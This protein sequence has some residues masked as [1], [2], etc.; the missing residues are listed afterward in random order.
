[1]ESQNAQRVFLVRLALGLG[2][3]LA[4]DLLYSAFDQKAWPATAPQLFAPLAVVAVFVPL[5]VSQGLGNI[6]ATTLL[7]WTAAATL[8]VAGL[9]WY[10]VWRAWPGETV[11]VELSARTIFICAVFLFVAHA[12]VSCGDADRRI[13][14][15]YPTLF[16]LAWKLG[17]QAAIVVCFVGAFWIMLFLGIAL[18]D[19]IKLTGFERFIEHPWVAIPLTT[20]AAAA[21]IEITDTRAGLVRGVRTLALT[22]LGWLLPV[23]GGIAFAF[24][25]SLAFTGLQPLWETRSATFLLIAAAAVLVVHINAAYQ[26]GD[27]ERRPPHILRVAGTL[28]AVLL[29]F[30]VWIAGYALWLRVNQYGWTVDRITSAAVVLVAGMFAIGYLVAAILPGLWLK[31]IERWNVYG[32]FFFLI[33]LFALS[34]PIA[35]PMRLS[36]DSQV[37]RLQSGVVKPEKFDFWYLRNAGGRFGHAALEALKSSPNKAIREAAIAPLTNGPI[38][39]QSISAPRPDDLA[40]AIAVYP[41]GKKLPDS[42][43]T[44]DWMKEGE[45]VWEHRPCLQTWLGIQAGLCTAIVEDFDGDG[46]DDILMVQNQSAPP[47]DTGWN[48]VLLVHQRGKWQLVASTGYWPHCRGELAALKAGKFERAAPQRPLPELKFGDHRVPLL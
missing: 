8:I 21:A 28:A 23:I 4:L 36:V 3:G 41:P 45:N 18:F 5:L 42:F 31:L 37:A 34:T 11:P 2:Q 9:A 24:L 32:T 13:V 44:Q 38:P 14:A 20:L 6:R 47:E 12:L 16:D 35:D 19:M 29:I 43:L 46:V 30:V 15:R 25:V 10:D 1:M 26:D 33:V 39:F 27:P 17:V 7:V 22:L 40:R 48:A